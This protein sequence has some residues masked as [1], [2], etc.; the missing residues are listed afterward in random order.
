[1]RVV[2]IFN[3]VQGEGQR[4]GEQTTFIRLAGCNVR[5]NWCDTKYAQ[6]FQ[7]GREMSYMDILSSIEKAATKNVCVTGGEPLAHPFAKELLSYLCANGCRVSVETNGTIDL[8]PFDRRCHYVVDYKLKSSGVKEKFKH[9]NY[10]LA[11]EIKLVINTREDFL[12]AKRVIKQMEYNAS[13]AEAL[14]SPCWNGELRSKDIVE[15]ML[16][17]KLKAR[18]SLQLHKIIWGPKKRCV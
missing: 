16:K 1:M 5:C 8:T 10:A 14:L 7:A 17:F 11:N 3:S 12:E 6:S 13:P 18:L 4:A 15:L 2:E 9:E